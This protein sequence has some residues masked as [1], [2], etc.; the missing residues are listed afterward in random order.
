MLDLIEINK[1]KA[2]TPGR[3]AKEELYKYAVELGLQEGI[4]QTYH[5]SKMIQIMEKND[6]ILN[7]ENVRDRMALMSDDTKSAFEE[8][9]EELNKAIPEFV[10]RLNSIDNKSKEKDELIEEENL[11]QEISLRK[12]IPSIAPIGKN[13]SY[14]IIP[15]WIYDHIINNPTTWYKK[16]PPFKDKSSYDIALSLIYYIRKDGAVTIR[17]TR[18]SSFHTFIK[19]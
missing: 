7:S 17:E 10:E 18:F 1:I 9:N 19:G 13:P 5:I 3:K 12:N 6:V 4:K 14:I 16:K 8:Y 15:F 2:I 11:I